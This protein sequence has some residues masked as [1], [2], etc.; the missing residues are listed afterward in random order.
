MKTTAET[1]M[2]DHSEWHRC[3]QGSWIRSDTTKNVDSVC[4]FFRG[5][6]TDRKPSEESVTHGDED[7][8]KRG[9]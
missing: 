5:E 3:R 6:E 9:F 2:Y 1:T 7:A 4:C 8:A